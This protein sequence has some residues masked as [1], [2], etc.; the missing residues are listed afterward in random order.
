INGTKTFSS[1]I[2]GSVS[3]SASSFTGA[4]VGDVTG[5]QGATS[6]VRLQGRSVS[7][8]A[9]MAGDVLTWTGAQWAPAAPAGGGGGGV[10]C[11]M[12]NDGPSCVGSDAIGQIGWGSSTS[13]SSALPSGGSSEHWYT[14]S[15]ANSGVSYHPHIYISSGGA[16]YTVDVYTDCAGTALGCASEG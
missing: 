3:G 13:R 16:Y 5:T 10:S 14:V 11:G 2:I 6:V 8:G 9:P 12:V 4:L 1:T 15:W 7:A